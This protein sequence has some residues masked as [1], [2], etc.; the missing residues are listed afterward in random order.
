[1]PKK[2]VT[3]TYPIYQIEY[4]KSFMVVMLGLEMRRLMTILNNV[5]VSTLKHVIEEAE[6][7]KS[8]GEQ[9]DRAKG[10][11]LKMGKNRS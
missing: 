1:M 3:I 4:Y 2:R 8:K 9:K 11:T 6:T 5:N 10:E 7:D